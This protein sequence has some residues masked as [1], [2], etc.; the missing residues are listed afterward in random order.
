MVLVGLLYQ[1]S[2]F[3]KIDIKLKKPECK[4]LFIWLLK[5]KTP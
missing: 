3:E 5:T 1:F 2:Q 4:I